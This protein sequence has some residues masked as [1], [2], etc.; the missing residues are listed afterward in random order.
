MIEV[1]NLTKWYGSHVAVDDLSFTVDEGSV[2]GFLGPNGAGK[3]TTMNILTGYLAPSEG[4]VVINGYNIQD[5]PEKAKKTIGYLPEI[6][7]LYPDMTVR[8]YLAFAAELKKVP[9]KD[10]KAE[11]AR[12]MDELAISD[13]ADRM[14]RNLSKGYKQRVGFAQAL[15][16][17]PET[18]ILDEPTVG[19]DPK[20]IIEIRELIKELGK[21]HTVILSSH[22]LAEVSE[23]CDT[24]M[25]ISHG[26]LVA[27]DTPENLAKSRGEGAQV[28]I[29]SPADEEMLRRALSAFAGEEN[30][31]IEDAKDGLL[32]ATVNYG[33]DGDPRKEAVMAMA[34]AACPYYSVDVKMASLEDIFLELTEAEGDVDYSNAE[35][36]MSDDEEED[37]ADA[38][39]ESKTDEAVAAGASESIEDEELENAETVASETMEGTLKSAGAGS[40][41]TGADE[42]ASSEAMKEGTQAVEDAEPKATEAAAEETLGT[43]TEDDCKKTDSATSA[44]SEAMEQSKGGEDKS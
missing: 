10:R 23:I 44:A 31:S 21:K 40:E 37:G 20:Q 18:L 5:E 17:N 25:I 14:I 32:T 39:A 1:K 38:D 8:E 34:N 7:P 41:V 27:L 9:R 33:G 12:V 2:Y 15:V 28:I 43:I 6:P 3:S 29:T 24:I 4:E 22:I 19:L 16:G 30:I 13:V 11:V 35:V 26:R 36:D 42:C